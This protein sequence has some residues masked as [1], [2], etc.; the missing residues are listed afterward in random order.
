MVRENPLPARKGA[1]YV[2]AI[3][4]AVEYAHQQGTLHRD[5][6]PSNVLID[7][8]GAVHV[9]DFGLAARVEGDNDLT[10]TG[11]ALGTPAYMPPEQ[12]QGKR[13]LIGP[14][15]DVYSLG[16]IL[17]ELLTGRPPFKA[18]SSMQTLQQVIE[19]EPAPLRLLNPKTPRD[20]ETICLKCLQKQTHKRYPTAAELAADLGRWLNGEAIRAR[21]VGKFERLWRW[22]RRHP[23]STALLASVLLMVA[24]LFSAARYA[25]RCS[26]NSQRL[27][28]IPAT[29]CCRHVSFFRK[30]K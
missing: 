13:S 18:E 28:S 30:V 17:Y 23:S 7:A 20:L 4:A 25:A 10:R 16:V 2:Q 26:T 12:A 1:E 19:S 9:M 3:A 27:G 24:A 6:K 11:Q 29:I 8:D 21:P 5:L 14:A 22:C 15:S